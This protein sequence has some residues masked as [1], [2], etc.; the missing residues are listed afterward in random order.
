M[1][2]VWSLLAYFDF[3]GV[4]V[5]GQASR[6]RHNFCGICKLLCDKRFGA[7]LRLFAL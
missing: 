1:S 2:N 3:F 7:L 4:Q 5:L 6:I